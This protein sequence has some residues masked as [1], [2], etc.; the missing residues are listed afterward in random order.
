[1]KSKNRYI[2]KILFVSACLLMGCDKGLDPGPEQG[3]EQKPYGFSGTI[4]FQNWPPQDSV[5]DLRVVAFLH[6][7]PENI[8][9]DVRQGK[10]KYTE[11]LVSA[12]GNTSVTYTLLLSP[13]PPGRYEYIVVAQ[14]FG[15]SLLNDWRAVGVYYANN[16]TTQ[17]GVVNVPNN[18]IVQ[19]ININVDFNHLPPQP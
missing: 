18:V 4:Y 9:R 5:R 3:P 7:P 17:P 13:L 12:Y 10:A 16:D 1:M 11:S 6:Y 8:I 19:G 15:P 14:Q 2:I